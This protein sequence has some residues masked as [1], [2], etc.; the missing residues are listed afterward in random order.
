M[1]ACEPSRLIARRDSPASFSDCSSSRDA[2]GVVAG[3]IAMRRPSRAPYAT[4]STMSGRFSASP[5]LKTKMIGPKR[6]TSSSSCFASAVLSSSECRLGCASAR[7]CLHARSHACV[8]SQITRNG[9]RSKSRLASECPPLL[10]VRPIIAASWSG[11]DRKSVGEHRAMVG[12][13]PGSVRGRP[14]RSSEYRYE[15]NCRT[16]LRFVRSSSVHPADTGSPA[17]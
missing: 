14:L 10:P 6:R 2:N 3:V 13:I 4:S 17:R 15:V 1:P 11:D 16:T 8:V 7:Q 5:P 9:A 12:T